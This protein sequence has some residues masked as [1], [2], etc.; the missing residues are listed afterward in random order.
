M[1]NKW[2]QEDPKHKAIRGGTLKTHA[3]PEPIAN[4]ELGM[5]DNSA[6]QMRQN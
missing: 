5:F 4:C 3:M 1:A 6:S 2:D